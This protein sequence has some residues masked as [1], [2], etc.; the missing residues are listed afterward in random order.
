MLRNILANPRFVFAILLIGTQA[1]SHAETRQPKSADKPVT[2]EPR[3]PGEQVETATFGGG[4]FW[5][6]EAVFQRLK[7]VKTVVSGYC[8]GR[9]K[10]PS[11]QRVSSGMTGHAEA[12]QITYDP[13]QVSYTE[14]LEVFWKT[15]DPTTRNRQGPD[16]GTQYRSMVF[17][18]NDEQ[19]TRVEEVK[20]QLDR[21]GIFRGPIVTQIV[22]FREFFPAEDHHQNYFNLNPQQPYCAMMIRPKLEKLEKYFADKLKTAPHGAVNAGK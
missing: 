11:Y 18:H 21:A 4:C 8:G 3:Q 5:C 7:G 22:P 15:H 9:V 17:Y 12:V 16:V 19:K 2:E 10:D 14:L 1:M 6:T 20:S 13:S